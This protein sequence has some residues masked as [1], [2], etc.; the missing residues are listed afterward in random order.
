MMEHRRAAPTSII[1]PTSRCG[2]LELLAVLRCLRPD[3]ITPNAA[4]VWATVIWSIAPW[5]RKRAAAR[6]ETKAR[7]GTNQQKRLLESTQEGGR[8][9]IER[10]RV[11]ESC[12]VALPFR[13]GIPAAQKQMSL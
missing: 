5:G 6:S 10:G 11:K 4:G 7:T 1:L 9:D 13:V 2:H 3:S 8:G 12:Q